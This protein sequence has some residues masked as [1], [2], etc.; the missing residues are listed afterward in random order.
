M[1]GSPLYSPPLA[2]CKMRIRLGVSPPPARAACAVVCG[3]R[4]EVHGKFSDHT[5]KV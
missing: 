2:E 1:A 4:C 5:W 3:L